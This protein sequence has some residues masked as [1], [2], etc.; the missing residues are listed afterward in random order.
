MRISLL[1]ALLPLAL[2][3]HPDP[4]HTLDELNA[5]L[6]QAPNDQELLRQK[7][8]LYLSINQLA[9]AATIS[10]QLLQLG[11]DS[12]ENQLVDARLALA[13]DERD[14]AVAKARAIVAR[15]PKFTDGLLFLAHAEDTAGHRDHAIA[16]MRAY[17]EHAVEPGPSE[18]L[19]CAAWLQ[20]RG[21]SGD[22]EAA[23]A[24]LDLGL[25]KIGCLSGLHHK[26]IEIEL[27]L[28]RYDDALRRLD[29]L[30][31]RFR[32]SVDL[33][34]RRAAILENASRFKDA[35]DACDSALALL[36]ALPGPRKQSPAFRQ[37]FE[38]I[39]ARKAANLQK[40]GA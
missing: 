34:L 2:S 33:S 6:A 28:G 27:S 24:V 11:P 19:T 18:V 29:A 35:A 15:Q 30:A 8:A 39:A 9:E 7:A 37:Q 12:P 36:D 17:L 16:A 21:Q 14:S 1:L 10:T 3:A 20:A 25:A 38:A 4:R 31:A 26:A 22:A 40:S 13:K 5:H 23:V 32:P